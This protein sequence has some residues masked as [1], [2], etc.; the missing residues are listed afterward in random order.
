[1]VRFPQAVHYI[2]LADEAVVLGEIVKFDAT[3]P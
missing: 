3:L 2:F 1:M